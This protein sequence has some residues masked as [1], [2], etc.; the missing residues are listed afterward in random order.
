MKEIVEK[1]HVGSNTINTNLIDTSK[2]I[3]FSDSLKEITLN[4][5]NGKTKIKLNYNYLITIR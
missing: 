3:I 1:L 4:I 5:K 2:I